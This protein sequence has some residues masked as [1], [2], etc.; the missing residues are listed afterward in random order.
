[1]EEGGR[2]GEA[3]RRNEKKSIR[4]LPRRIR[5]VRWWILAEIIHA[6][7]MQINDFGRADGEEMGRKD[8]TPFDP[9]RVRTEYSSPVFLTNTYLL[10]HLFTSSSSLIILILVLI[11]PWPLTTSSSVPTL[12]R[13]FILLQTSHFI[14]N[15]GLVNRQQ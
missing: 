7:L 13:H 10:V 9:K 14:L 1:M 6:F 8:A 2:T 3:E 4:D 5:S 15:S 11:D 12:W